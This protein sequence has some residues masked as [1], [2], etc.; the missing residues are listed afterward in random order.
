MTSP[1]RAP[2]GSYEALATVYGD[3]LGVERVGLDDDF[4]ALGGDERTLPALAHAI[5]ERFGLP[6]SEEIIREAPTVA[7]LGARLGRRRPRGS[8]LVMQLSVGRSADTS[9]FFCV[10]GGGGPATQLHALVDSMPDPRPTASSSAA[11]RNA[12]GWTG[13]PARNA[14]AARREVRPS[15]P[16]APTSSVVTRTARWWHTRWRG[17]WSMREPKSGCS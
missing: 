8:P 2:R 14:G 6:V 7:A 12:T 13:V 10:A 15:N 5:Y 9:P 4:F 11:S 1:Y 16:L 17:S 3:V